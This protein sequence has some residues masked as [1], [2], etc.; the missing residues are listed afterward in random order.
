MDALL[1]TGKPQEISGREDEGA[2]RD[3]G[4]AEESEDVVCF[5]CPEAGCV[6]NMRVLQTYSITLTTESTSISLRLR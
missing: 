1:N 2:A 6:K 5:S 4:H 3:E